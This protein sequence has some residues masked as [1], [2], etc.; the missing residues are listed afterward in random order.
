MQFVFHLRAEQGEYSS[1]QL[2]KLE[3]LKLQNASIAL[4]ERPKANRM[5]R[6]ETRVLKLR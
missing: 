1:L 2:I 3:P 4:G 5:N 6:K